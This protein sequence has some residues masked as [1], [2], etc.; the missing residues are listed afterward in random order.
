MS[1]RD[2]SSARK[3]SHGSAA[4]SP[5]RKTAQSTS[6]APN[7]FSSHYWKSP[8]VITIDIPAQ[9]LFSYEGTLSLMSIL[10]HLDRGQH[11][12]I[13]MALNITEQDIHNLASEYNME[14]AA[15][16]SKL[17][18]YLRGNPSLKAVPPLTRPTLPI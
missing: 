17:L 9:K 14:T 18:L 2:R 7:L 15:T 16:L 4:T 10:Y 5:R 3:S 13:L 11:D 12:A 1:A 8:P 6:D